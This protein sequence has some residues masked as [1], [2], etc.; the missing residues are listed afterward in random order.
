[1]AWPSVTL[2]GAAAGRRVCL[3][4][5]HEDGADF[6]APLIAA[7]AGGNHAALR[8]IYDDQ[9]PRLK[10][11]AWRITGSAAL[12]EDVLHDV[13]LRLWQDAARFDPAKGTGRIWLTTL[14]RY[15]ALDVL[16]RR[17]RE[18][19]ADSLPEEPDDSPDAVARLVASAEGKALHA[20][21]QGLDAPRRGMITAAFVHGRSHAELSESLN[22]PLGTIKS[23][24]RRS[25]AALR[26]CLES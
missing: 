3:D 24:I 26:K 25:L 13:F 7:C 1:M 22:I 11:L 19:P 14:T 15:R 23:T 10:A 21:L 9:A 2:M 18:V 16:R 12:A 4:I 20:C 6:L 5:D 17:A 8:A